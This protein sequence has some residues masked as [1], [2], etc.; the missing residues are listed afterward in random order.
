MMAGFEGDIKEIRGWFEGEV[1]WDALS[2]KQ[3]RRSGNMEKK[4]P[5]S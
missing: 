4:K 3:K 5:R 1:G 2:S